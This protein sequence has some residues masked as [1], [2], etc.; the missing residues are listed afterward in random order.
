MASEIRARPQN[1][2]PRRRSRQSRSFGRPRLPAIAYQTLGLRSRCAA[3]APGCLQHGVCRQI[4]SSARLFIRIWVH[5]AHRVGPSRQIMH[6]H[7]TNILH[8]PLPYDEGR[9]DCMCGERRA[10]KRRGESGERGG[11]RGLAV[12]PCTLSRKRATIYFCSTLMSG[13]MSPELPGLSRP[14]VAA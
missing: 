6:I 8:L 14:P 10:S 4:V 2:A 1:G 13:M 11:A 12:G 7:C 9:G 3:A 5:W